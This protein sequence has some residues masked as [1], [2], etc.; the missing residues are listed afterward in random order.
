MSVH[1]EGRVTRIEGEPALIDHGLVA[2]AV[3]IFDV[4]IDFADLVPLVWLAHIQE[5]WPQP[6]D[7]VLGNVSQGLAHSST[8]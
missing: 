6:T 4:D 3:E 7:R 2:G 1:G 8:K 5:M